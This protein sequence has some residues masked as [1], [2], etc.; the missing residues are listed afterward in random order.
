MKELQ[1]AVD[2]ENGDETFEDLQHTLENLNDWCD[3]IDLANGKHPSHFQLNAG[4]ITVYISRTR[5]IVILTTDLSPAFF[6]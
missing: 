2:L 4:K 3:H 5:I 1:E 6:L